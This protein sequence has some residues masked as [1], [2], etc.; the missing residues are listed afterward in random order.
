[1]LILKFWKLTTAQVYYQKVLKLKREKIQTCLKLFVKE[2][3]E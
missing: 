2:I 3:N 1:M